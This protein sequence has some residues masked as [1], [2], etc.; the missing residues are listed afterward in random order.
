MED[1]GEKPRFKASRQVGSEPGVEASGRMSVGGGGSSSV[2]PI[3][4]EYSRQIQKMM[5]EG[6][7]QLKRYVSAHRFLQVVW[8]CPPV[9]TNSLVMIKMVSPVEFPAKGQSI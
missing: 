7:P 2:D 4:L 5:A 1:P 3:D 9:N 6:F 8:L